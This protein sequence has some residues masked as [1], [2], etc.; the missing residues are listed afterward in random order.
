VAVYIFG[1]T[2]FAAVL[3]LR[4]ERRSA[5]QMAGA[6]NGSE[7]DTGNRSVKVVPQNYVAA[8]KTRGMN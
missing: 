5:K 4:K 6:N 7:N 8:Q 2:Y 3:Q 1:G